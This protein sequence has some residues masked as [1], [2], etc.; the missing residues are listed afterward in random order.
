MSTSRERLLRLAIILS[1][2]VFV[3]FGAGTIPDAATILER[4]RQGAER[5][6]SDLCSYSVQRTYTLNNKHLSKEAK[7]IFLMS[8]DKSGGKKFKLVSE[9]NT[10]TLI[11][12]SILDLING[13]VASGGTES[14]KSQLDAAN[15]KLWLAGEESANGHSC[16]KI[17]LDPRNK[18]KYLLDGYAW[19]D[20]NRFTLVKIK[21]QPAKSVSFWASHPDFEQDF[22]P[23]HAF[24]LPTYNHSVAHITFFGDTTLAI[25]YGPY[26]IQACSNQPSQTAEER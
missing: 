24:W 25:E 13:E 19:I 4:F 9:E 3:S 14:D 10:N 12:H 11:R 26:E 1:L 8:Y 21:G 22:G 6:K 20:T 15:Y 16:Y 18:G 5:Q 23:I 2:A 17:R 7:M